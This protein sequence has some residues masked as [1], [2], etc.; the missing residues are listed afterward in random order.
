MVLQGSLYRCTGYDSP[1]SSCINSV[2]E[3][4]RIPPKLP[5]EYQELFEN[6]LKVRTR[7]LRDAIDF[8]IDE[9]E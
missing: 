5:Q 1:W 2:K 4:Q 8:N 9:L 6:S 7:I 3:P